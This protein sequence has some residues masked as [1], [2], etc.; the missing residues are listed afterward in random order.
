MKIRR[1]VSPPILKEYF[2]FAQ[3][4][5]R[6][7]ET[8]YLNTQVF[9]GFSFLCTFIFL[10]VV[11]GF[12]Y[13]TFWAIGTS[14]I[15]LLVFLYK[16]TSKLCYGVSIQRELPKFCREKSE[17]TIN[18]IISNTTGFKL[19]GLS[20]TEMFDGVQKGFFEVECNKGVPAQ[21]Q[22]KIEKKIYLNSGMG[23]KSF[24][25]LNIKLRDDLGIFDFKV[26]F[27][28]DSELQVFPALE[29]TPKFINRISPD[30]IEY[31][32]YELAKRGDTNLFIGTREYRR[33]DPVKHINWKLTKKS[34]KV[35]VNEYEKSTNT[36]ITLLL[37]LNLK[38]QAGFGNM[39]TWELAK[40]LS[41]SICHNEIKRGNSI[42]VIS[43]NLYIPFGSGKTQIEILEKHFTYHELQNT[44]AQ[45]Q[46][47][48][49]S[50]LPQQSQIYYICPSLLT[51]EIKETLEILKKIRSQGNRVIIFTLDPYIE[52]ATTS[53]GKVKMTLFEIHRHSTNDLNAATKDLLQYGIP[54]IPITIT[55]DLN[56]YD[57]IIENSK[58]L[59]ETK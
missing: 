50:D 48:R 55:K 26:E 52:M 10:S 22:I 56:I 19:E 15:F 30:S 17:I 44:E 7:N 23:I 28:Q 38:H 32:I 39:S 37:E 11:V 47:K 13:S 46:F 14:T 51:L 49:L 12:F 40:D 29:E 41:L 9:N 6:L 33:G 24:K 42:Q 25:P 59:L 1:K 4:T 57:Q 5:S 43:N 8:F 34:T 36:Y 54:V 35:I 3:K 58:G 16:K 45:N 20:F 18:Y 27:F 2:H 21:T 53:E 31:G